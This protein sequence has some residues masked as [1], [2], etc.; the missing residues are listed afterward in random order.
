MEAFGN[1]KCVQCS[2]YIQDRDKIN[3]NKNQYIV[4][5]RMDEKLLNIFKMSFFQTE[6]VIHVQYKQK[7][8][9]IPPCKGN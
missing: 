5:G 4:N 1:F 6:A 8:L 3:S 9:M 2:L 7:K